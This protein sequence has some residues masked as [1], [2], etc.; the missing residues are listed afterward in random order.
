MQTYDIGL[1]PGPVSVPP[2]LRAVFQ[3]NYGSSDLEDEF[4]S[5]YQRCENPFREK[6][7]LREIVSRF[8]AVR[9]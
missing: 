7:W 5:L 1:V 8:K 4:F 9:A 3:I 2:E 6:Y